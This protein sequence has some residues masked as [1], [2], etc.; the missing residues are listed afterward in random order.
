MR[1]DLSIV[2]EESAGRWEY[3]CHIMLVALVVLEKRVVCRRE[4]QNFEWKL[5]KQHIAA[6]RIY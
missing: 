4:I 2:E 6:D 5:G 1:S 3:E